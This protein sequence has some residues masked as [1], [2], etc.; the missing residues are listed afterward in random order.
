MIR[1][2]HLLGAIAVTVIA[3]CA[4]SGTALG[5]SWRNA[6]PSSGG[7]SSPTILLSNSPG[8]LPR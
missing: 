3:L 4:F 7:P 5:A 6:I 8:N 2:F 1:R